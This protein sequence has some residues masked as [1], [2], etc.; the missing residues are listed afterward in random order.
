M[1]KINTWKRRTPISNWVVLVNL[2][3]TVWNLLY[4][5]NLW[6]WE[7]KQ[8]YKE[9][10]IVF[11]VLKRSTSN[12]S[13]W[14]FYYGWTFEEQMYF[15]TAQNIVVGLS[16]DRDI[17]FDN[18]RYCKFVIRNRYFLITFFLLIA[19]ITFL[20]LICFII[21]PKGHLKRSFINM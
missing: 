3:L 13:S 2:M 19:F 20:C 5:S 10:N 8:L 17:I 21:S 9:W 18:I 14:I 16:I 7:Y 1:I 6:I 15:S 4:V 12:K 11:V